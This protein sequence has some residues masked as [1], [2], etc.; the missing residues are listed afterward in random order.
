ML[1]QDIVDG[2]K[3][4]PELRKLKRQPVY[5]KDDYVRL[6]TQHYRDL[7]LPDPAWIDEIPDSPLAPPPSPEDTEPKLRSHDMVSL[8][9]DYDEDAGS[10]QCRLSY[11]LCDLYRDY[12]SQGIPPPIESLVRSYKDL[13]F[14]DEYLMDL[15]D[16]HD[17]KVEG[18]KKV[19]AVI[20]RVFKVDSTTKKKKK[21]EEKPD[22]V[23]E[24]EEE[25]EEEEDNEQEEEEEDPFD[26]EMDE[27]DDVE[28]E[29]VS[30]EN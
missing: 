23:E 25:E 21:K 12:Y 20:D 19:G 28:E 14:S 24:E 10:V 11:A 17:R 22:I 9:I 29:Y 30:D 8:V 16:K 13:G 6:I 15:I 7:G 1:V 5:R 3:E 27:D 18:M 2:L 26:M 4:K